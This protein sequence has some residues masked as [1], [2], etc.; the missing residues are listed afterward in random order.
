MGT[1]SKPHLPLAGLFGVTA[2]LASGLLFIVEPLVARTLL[3][4]LGGSA[5]VWNSAMLTFQV[6]LLGGYLVAHL[7]ARHLGLRWHSPAAAALVL[8]A[9]AALPVGLRDGWQP[10]A[11]SPVVWTLF[12]VAVAVG[13]PFLAL[14]S[15]SPTL[16]RWYAAAAPG[17]D[18]YVLYAAGNA[19]SFIG[20]LAYPLVVERAFGLTDQRRLWTAGYLAFAALFLVCAAVAR[21]SRPPASAPSAPVDAGE[22]GAGAR[23]LLRWAAMAAGPSLLLLGATRHLSTDLAA[24]PLLW[25][26]PLS[27]YLLTFVVAFS[28]R[29]ATIGAGAIRMAPALAAVAVVSLAATLPV[30]PGL[31][32]HLAGFAVLAMAVHTRL[33]GERPPVADLT[34]FYLALSAGGAVGGVVGGLLAPVTL[35]GVWEYPLGVVACLA[36]LTPRTALGPRWRPVAATVVVALLAGASAIRLPPL[37]LG[38][39]LVR[40]KLGFRTLMDVIPLDASLI[41][42]SHGRIPDDPDKGPLLMT[43]HAD[44]LGDELTATDV[45]DLILRHLAPAG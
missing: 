3:P 28:G 19:G 16:Q 38:S 18:A 37:A 1:G 6:L 22:A 14:A 26:V 10:P 36:C 8:V 39:R 43:R 24:I 2:F 40:K 17:V 42:G 15:V 35:P 29:G 31:A 45:H 7:G 44:L 30:G 32:L 20:L 34:R 41:K 27:L 12:A 4:V 23:S 25:V 21:R 33:A 11:G 5:S 9:A 13:G